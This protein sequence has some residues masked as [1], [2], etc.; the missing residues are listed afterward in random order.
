MTF[1]RFQY[2]VLGTRETKA[3]FRELD[4]RVQGQIMREAMKTA[5][6]PAYEKAVDL[7]PEKSGRLKDNIKILGLRGRSRN[8]ITGARIVTGTRKQLRIAPS[9]KFYY[10]AAHEYGSTK[11]EGK[12]F[13]RAAMFLRRRRCIAIAKREIKKL[14]EANWQ[15]KNAIDKFKRG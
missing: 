4:R 1:S 9:N 11:M 15:L 2:K 12:S 3:A 6:V 13:L 5:I 14:L 7:A 8:G 10:P